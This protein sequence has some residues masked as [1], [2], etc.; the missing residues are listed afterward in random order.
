MDF[1][2]YK[3]F[4]WY[5]RM[6]SVFT[7]H[8]TEDLYDVDMFT[9]DVT[10]EIFIETDPQNI[11]EDDFVYFQIALIYLVR[12]DM[13]IEHFSTE[14]LAVLHAELIH[15]GEQYFVNKVIFKEV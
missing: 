7:K 6:I 5:Q 1:G 2:S 12:D 3:V 14:G 8:M 4:S 9:H 11:D 13:L 10:Q 15:N